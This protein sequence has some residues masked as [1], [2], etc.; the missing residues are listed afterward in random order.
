MQICFLQLLF[1][2]I[3]TWILLGKSQIFNLNFKTKK[4]EKKHLQKVFFYFYGALYFS[5]VF[6]LPSRLITEDLDHVR[7]EPR[8]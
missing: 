6:F 2:S 3:F 7:T 5:F 8:V 1:Q 4:K